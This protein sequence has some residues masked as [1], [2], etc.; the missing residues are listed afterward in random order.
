MLPD[1]LYVIVTASRRTDRSVEK[2][3]EDDEQ[4]PAP[5][6]PTRLEAE[7]SHRR[8][9]NRLVGVSVMVLVL[10]LIA[11]AGGNL[12]FAGSKKAKTPTGTSSDKKTTKTDGKT[13]DDVGT[14]DEP[15]DA[16]PGFQVTQA[17]SHTFALSEG[18]GSRPAGSARESATADYIVQRLGEMGYTVEEQPFTMSSGFGSRNVMGTREGTREGYTMIIAAH[19]DSAEDNKGAVNNATGVGVVLELARVFSSRKLESTLQFVFLGANRPGGSDPEERWVGARRYLD[20]LGT[21]EKK[22]VVGMISVDSV[23]QGDVFALR[24]QETG[25]QRLKAKMETYCR[26][27]GTE[28]SVLKSTDDSDNIPFESTQVP[29]VWVEWCDPGGGLATDNLYTSVVASK[30][31]TAGVTVERF[32]MGLSSTDLEELKY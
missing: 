27:H 24:T 18:I 25:L 13:G 31:E 32:L 30:V 19:Y 15:T 10:G 26:E 17:M 20:L 7:R 2:P 29:A 16:A 6:E 12:I 3:V 8:L 5:E 1:P 14:G 11:G 21:L 22:D 4:Q 9:V 23:G 28:V